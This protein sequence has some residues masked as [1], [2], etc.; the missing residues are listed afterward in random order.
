MTTSQ[1]IKT[2]DI[3]ILDKV[4][5]ME[6][7]WV[8]NFVDKSYREFFW[9]ELGVD[10]EAP[11]YGEQGS[12]AKRLRFFLKQCDRSTALKALLAL[13]DYREASAVVEDY[14][15]LNA[16][17]TRAFFAIIKRLGGVT[18]Q[19]LPSEPVPNSTKIDLARAKALS[20]RL[21]EVSKLAPHPRGY[22]FESFLK[23]VFDAYG[24]S[25][26]ASFRLIGEQ[27]DGS[28]VLAEQTYLLEAKWTD[29]KIDAQTLH[30]FN[31]KLE[32]KAAW[33][34][35]LFI[36][37]SGFTDVGLSAFGRGKRMVCMDG[38]DLYEILSRKLD[39]AEI[40]ALKVR[41]AAETGQVFVSVRDLGF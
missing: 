1:Q 24:L 20:N 17:V 33:S 7:G 11:P 29:A 31:G 30:G 25:P 3:P 9:E 10:L 38:L 16:D 21:L 40:L 36:S 19:T 15:E 8:L 34:R 39:F 23:E 2:V 28:F 26:R 4:F 18:P 35:G 6:G 32:E 14:E 5:E 37:Q 27:I 41:R 22:A 12:K 13:W